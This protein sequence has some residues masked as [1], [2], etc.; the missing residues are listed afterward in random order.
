[1]EYGAKDGGLQAALVLWTWSVL[2]FRMRAYIIHLIYPS[3]VINLQLPLI[4]V[5]YCRN[6]FIFTGH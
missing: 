3:A 6:K 5:K 2:G 4:K 1:M